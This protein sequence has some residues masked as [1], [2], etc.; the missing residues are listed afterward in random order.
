[1][2]KVYFAT[3]NEGKLKEA[4]NILGIEVE[5]TGLEVD[6]IQSMDPVEVAVKKARAY[7]EKLK[8]PIFV[9]DISFSIK[10]LNGLP[11]P[12]IDAFLK[13]LGNEG[14]IEVMKGREDRRVEVQATVVYVPKKGQEEIFIGKAEGIISDKPRGTGFG[15]DPIFIP[16]GETRTFG[17]MS[18]D[19]KNKY[20]MRAKALKK[21]KEWLNRDK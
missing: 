20:S 3:H 17:E 18:L 8:K 1:M 11:G 5:G 12:Y 6:E 21:L 15:W 9:E 19:E 10:A 4:Q 2:K 14:I 13:T 16:D 7:Y